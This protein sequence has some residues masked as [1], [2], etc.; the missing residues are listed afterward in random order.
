MPELPDQI[1]AWTDGAAL[2][3]DEQVTLAEVPMRSDWM[4]PRYFLSVAVTE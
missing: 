1:R 3:D 4:K 2:G